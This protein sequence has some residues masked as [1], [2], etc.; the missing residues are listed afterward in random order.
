MAREIPG[1]A[2]AV[3]T[4]G[5]VMVYAGLRG[6][7]VVQALRDVVSGAPP[8]VP[9]RSAGLDDTAAPQGVVSSGPVI[10][11]ARLVAEAMKNKGDRYSQARRWEPGYS[12]CS[13]F[14]GKALKQMGLTP[15][16]ASITWNYL[17]WSDAFKVDRSKVVAGDLAVN[18]TH[19]VLI[20]SATHA[21]GQQNPSVNVQE[22]TIEHLM[23][24]TGSFV[25]LRLRGTN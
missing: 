15:P 6:T 7:S 9:T 21:I 16:G 22:D 24:G 12:D 10:I 13:S 17:A 20:T 8:A 4:A 2:V 19:M 11:G 14:V 3:A 18:A 5:A 1:L 23:A 25:C